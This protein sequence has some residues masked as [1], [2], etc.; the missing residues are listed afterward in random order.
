MTNRSDWFTASRVRRLQSVLEG[1]HP[2]APGFAQAN[3]AQVLWPACGGPRNEIADLL[4]VLTLVSLSFKPNVSTEP[5]RAN[6]SSR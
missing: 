6:G 1:L 2:R 5:D 4:D 3:A